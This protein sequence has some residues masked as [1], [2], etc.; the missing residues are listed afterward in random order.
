MKS[1]DQ[2][3][4]ETDAKTLA[5][6]E[7]CIMIDRDCVKPSE[8][9]AYIESVCDKLAAEHPGRHFENT[10][11]PFNNNDKGIIWW[12]GTDSAV[13]D[14]KKLDNEML[15]FGAGPDVLDGFNFLYDFDGK[16]IESSRVSDPAATQKNSYEALRLFRNEIESR[17]YHAIEA[18]KHIDIV[19]VP[20][21]F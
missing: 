5:F 14:A 1:Y 13:I 9:A 20:M 16:F 4:N 8:R 7:L 12:I 18:G 2:I 6:D 21:Y 19:I 10:I 15:S 11:N 17:I 3:C